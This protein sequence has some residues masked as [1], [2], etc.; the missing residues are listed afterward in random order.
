MKD[1]LISVMDD[2]MDSYTSPD[3]QKPLK[4]SKVTMYALIFFIFLNSPVLVKS[5][6]S[7]TGLGEIFLCS[8]TSSQSF[9]ILSFIGASKVT[10]QE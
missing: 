9:I 3:S 2:A 8:W 6:N 5:N 4:P 10:G 1:D 7:T